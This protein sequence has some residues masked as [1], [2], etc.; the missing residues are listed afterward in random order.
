MT[1]IDV[2]R[3]MTAAEAAAAEAERVATRDLTRAEFEYLLA[4]TGFEDVWS[5]L[6]AALKGSD[7]ALYAT[8]RSQR[9]MP[10][11]RLT[12]TLEFVALARPVLAQVLPG[13]DLSDT[14]VKTAWAAV[15]AQA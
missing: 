3:I 10:R 4:S 14:A 7:P 8:I 13:V 5:A 1:Q 6:E 2:S 11:F 9:V 12:K 15:A